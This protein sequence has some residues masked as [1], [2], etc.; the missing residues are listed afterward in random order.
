LPCSSHYRVLAKTARLLEALLE[1][2][3]R[4]AVLLEE[5]AAGVDG[6][7]PAVVAAA[8]L[9]LRPV[10]WLGLRTVILTS[11]AFG[12]FLS[13]PQ[14]ASNRL[15]P[16]PAEAAVAARRVVDVALAAAELRAELLP[17]ATVLP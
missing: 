16:Q 12:T 9:R 15:R 17:V 8:P 14:Q 6:V 1:E 4:A 11:V 5:E 13:L 3:V 7:V 2:V 10:P